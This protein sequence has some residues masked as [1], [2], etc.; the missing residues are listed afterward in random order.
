MKEQALKDLLINGKTL[1][2]VIKTIFDLRIINKAYPKIFERLI[3]QILADPNEFKRLIKTDNDFYQLWLLCPKYEDVFSQKTVPD[4][5]AAM[6]SRANIVK[7][8]RLLSQSV[9]TNSEISTQLPT[10]LLF[11]IGMFARNTNVHS[12]EQAKSMFEASFAKPQLQN[13]A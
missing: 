5:V 8:S 3:K 12:R 9:R 7:T 4:A 6:H 2:D 10:E 13:S 11:E 1:K